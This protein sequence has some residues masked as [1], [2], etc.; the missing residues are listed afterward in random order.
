MA[1][2]KALIDFTNAKIHFD[3]PMRKHISLGVGGSARFYAEIDS[4]YSLNLLIALAKEYKIKYKIIGNGTNVLISD[5]GY[6]GLIID[7]KKLNDIF[8]KKSDIRAMAGARLDKLIR[9]AVDNRLSGIEALSGI[10]A[11]IGGAIVMNAGAFGYNISNYLLTVETLCDGKIK[12]YN[13]EDCRFGYRTSR[14]LGKKEAIV[15]AT[16]RFPNGDKEIIKANMNCYLELRRSIQPMQRSCGSVF[17]N[18]KPHSAGNLIEKAGLKGY[19]IGGASISEKHANFI[20]TSAKAKAQDVY[21]LIEYIKHKV[22][23]EFGIELKEEVEYIG[24]F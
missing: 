17:K 24:E 7:M 13:R 3:E 10:P 12:I 5:L 20:I 2:K 4:L 8:F 15:S 23:D 1:F 19:R 18:P 9:F 6:D 14:F 11:S 16:F 22:K 21:C